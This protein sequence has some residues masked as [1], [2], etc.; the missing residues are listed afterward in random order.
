MGYLGRTVHEHKDRLC[1]YCDFKWR[2]PYTFSDHL[3]KCHPDVDPDVILHQADSTRRLCMYCDVEWKHT[4]EYKDHLKKHH[5][6]LDPDAVLGEAPWSQSRDKIIARFATTMTT[7]TV[8]TVMGG[9]PVVG[10]R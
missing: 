4:Y 8:T 10:R 7:T 1:L 3:E 5:P 6:N 9:K 2:P